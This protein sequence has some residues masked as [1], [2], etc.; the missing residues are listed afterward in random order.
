MS[1]TD[2]KTSPHT[3]PPGFTP[4]ASP[5]VQQPTAPLLAENNPIMIGVPPGLGYLTQIN[6]FSVR[7][8]FSAS[9][10]WSTR[11]FDVLNPAS[12]IIYQATKIN[13][14]C[15]PTMDVNIKDNNGKDVMQLQDKLKCSCDRE[16]QV[17]ISPGSPAGYIIL[18][19][20]AMVTHLS[21]LDAR[22]EAV[23]MI[24]GPSLNT[25]IFGNAKFE[26]KSRDEQHVVGIIQ[27]ESEQFVASFPLDL[28]VTIKAVLLGACFYLDTLISNQRTRVQRRD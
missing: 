14:I 26:V 25:V 19:W 5:A 18:H 4:Y 15:G 22:K 3:D 13:H 17:L 27:H 10:G 21:V 24:I 12:Q 11:S 9:Q 2:F 6:Q 8:K 23:L 16:L 1:A 7:E 28:D 20:N